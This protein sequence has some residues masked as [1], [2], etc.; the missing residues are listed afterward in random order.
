MIKTVRYVPLESML[1]AVYATLDHSILNYNDILEWAYDAMEA[2]EVRYTFQERVEFLSV[3][4]HKAFVPTGLKYVEQ[5]L[6]KL[7]LNSDDEDEI[8]NISRQDQNGN[9]VPSSISADEFFLSPLIS[10]DWSPLR[11]ASSIFSR[12]VHCATS[13][14]LYAIGEHEYTIDPNGCIITS[15]DEGFLAIGYLGHPKNAEG[16]FLVPDERDYR[17]AVENY[18]LFKHWEVRFNMKEEGADKRMIY[19]QQQWE[20]FAAKISGDMMMP[21]IDGMQNLQDQ[22]LRI[23]QNT[24]SYFTGFGNLG[25]RETLNFHN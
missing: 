2:L 25:R 19:Y 22:L 3:V 13:V 8:I 1:K 17:R 5:I 24:G 7:Q 11:L 16:K 14:N 9:I 23:G 20:L 21:S 4:N 15:F 10:N 18:I 6:Y 12:T